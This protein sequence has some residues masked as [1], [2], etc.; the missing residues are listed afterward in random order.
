MITKQKAT[1]IATGKEIFV[2]KDRD[3]M[4]YRNYFK[5]SDYYTSNELEFKK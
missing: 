2:Y 5:P 3:T 1:I 4:V